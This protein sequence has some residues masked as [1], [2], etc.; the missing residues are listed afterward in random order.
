MASGPTSVCSQAGCPPTRQPVSSG[1]T[2]SDWP[3]GLADGLVDRLTAGGGPQH[4]VDAAAPTERDAEEALQAAGDLAVR[5]AALLVEFDDGGLGIGSQ[6]G[7][8]GT[9]GVGRLQ[10]MA[11]LNPAVALPALADVDVELPVNGLARDFDLELLGDVGFVEGAAAVG[12]DVG[13]GRLVDLV[14][15]FGAG[16]LAMG[17]GAVV[18]AGL[19]A[20]L[21]GLGAGLPLGERGGLALAGTEGLVE[22]AAEALVLGLQVVDP[23][24]KGLAASTPDRFHSS[25]IPASR[26][27][28]CIRCRR[29]KISLSLRR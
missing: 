11:A 2:Q 21:L 4:G 15:L 13:Q 3:T 26:P 28:S 9:E 29:V 18:L 23:S 22:L 1:T 7:G 12:A 16:R 5:Q 20:G 10:G 25:I 27:C 19:A 8:G 24:L 14:D 6:L 17:L